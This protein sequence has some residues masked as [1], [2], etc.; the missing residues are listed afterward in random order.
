M[1]LVLI[2]IFISC[3]GIK[4][5]NTNSVKIDKN[6]LN[7]EIESI[8]NSVKLP[9]GWSIHPRELDKPTLNLQGIEKNWYMKKFESK[10]DVR[11]LES[12]SES[13]INSTCRRNIIK[14]NSQKLIEDAI[15]SS[16][17]ENTTVEILPSKY[18]EKSDSSNIEVIDCKNI[19]FEGITSACECYLGF[20]IKGGRASLQERMKANK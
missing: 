17:E 6:E 3:A 14:Q 7:T 2:L 15:L 9:E 20:Y 5:N 19:V 8:T 10:P 11:A 13:F 4:L 18:I 16:K 12:K 1:K